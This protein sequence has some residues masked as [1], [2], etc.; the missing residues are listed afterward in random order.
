MLLLGSKKLNKKPFY[1]SIDFED[2]TYDLTRSLGIEPLS[3]IPALH[4]AYDVI[5][6]FLEKNLSNPKVTFFT[7]GTVARLAP[8]LLKQ[9]SNDGHEIAS[10]YNY[11]DLMF[12]QSNNEIEKNLIEAK[13][14]IYKAVGYEPL[15]FRAPV[16]SIPLERRDIFDVLKKHF[17]YDSSYVIHPSQNK[18]SNYKNEI[19]LNCNDFLEVPV[20]TK[21]Y[22]LDKF[23]MKSGGTFLRFFS[24]KMLKDTMNHSYDNGYYPL[25]YLHPY[26]YL[27]G[28]EFWVTFDKFAQTKD[29]RNLIKYL[30]QIQWISIGNK[31]VFPKL[32]FLLESFEHQGPMMNLLD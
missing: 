26:D 8:D 15:G 1:F 10:H 16:F 24:K 23:Q 14:S 31:S 4:L 19:P 17:K 12:K 20:F 25:V 3:N 22:F 27:T 7:T 28:K 18:F 5:N 13:E 9:I 6:N 30:R 21:K 11:H 2:F 29:L 32:K